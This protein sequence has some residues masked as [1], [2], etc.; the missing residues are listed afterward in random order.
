MPG[1]IKTRNGS[2]AYTLKGVADSLIEAICPVY[3]LRSKRSTDQSPNDFVRGYKVSVSNDG[4]TFG[5]QTED[6]YI[7]DSTCQAYD[8]ASGE[9]IF[10]LKVTN[11]M[12]NIKY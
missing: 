6:V 5:N 4:T 11:Y 8:N 2:I 9:I 7:F 3:H 12:V 1:E 10:T